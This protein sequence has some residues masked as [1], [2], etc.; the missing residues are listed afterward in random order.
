MYCGRIAWL[1]LPA[2]LRNNERVHREGSLRRCGN[3]S[4]KSCALRPVMSRGMSEGRVYGLARRNRWIGLNSESHDPPVVFSR[5][6]L[7]DLLQTG[8]NWSYPHLPAPLGTP[9]DV[10]HH[11]VDVELLVLIL[12]VSTILFFNS[13][14]KS[15]G[16]FIPRL[17]PRGFLAHVL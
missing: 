7:N 1:T 5:Y 9:D 12:H 15:E 16:P 8:T 6:L 10:V 2:V 4:R 14:C 13:V 3:A 11:Q 17:K